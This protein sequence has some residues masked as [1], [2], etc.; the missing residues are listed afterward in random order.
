[1]PKEAFKSIQPLSEKQIK[2][3]KGYLPSHLALKL[4]KSPLEFSI[5]IATAYIFDVL[6]FSRD[7][8]LTMMW[9]RLVS[10]ALSTSESLSKWFLSFLA[11]KNGILQ[12]IFFKSP[13][14]VTKKAASQLIETALKTLKHTELPKYDEQKRAIDNSPHLASIGDV[15][16]WNIVMM[17]MLVRLIKDASTIGRYSSANFFQT[18]KMVC[19]I[20]VEERKFL[21]E[22]DCLTKLMQFIL[23]HGEY[24]Y[25]PPRG[26]NMAFAP[27]QSQTNVGSPNVSPPLEVLYSLLRGIKVEADELEDLLPPPTRY[28]EGPTISLNE[29]QN[30]LLFGDRF[31]V[32]V[33]REGS[34]LKVTGQVLQ[35]LAWQSSQK[36]DLFL[37]ALL[38]AMSVTNNPSSFVKYSTILLYLMEIEDD[39]Q[40]NRIQSCLKMIL[41]YVSQHSKSNEIAGEAM[42]FFRR[43]CT[44]YPAIQA[45]ISKNTNEINKVF[46]PAHLKL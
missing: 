45:W 30:A 28:P 42:Y 19:E 34:D 15:V 37:A 41:D 22:R 40:S 33:I 1:M 13:V 44:K 31:F 2:K 21:M 18:L 8:N 12:A 29:E 16:S 3:L 46:Q 10:N 32:R 5:A 35:Y 17:E 6:P 26:K 25:Q 38:D 20:G 14:S 36:T 24:A 9:T 11:T 27:K 43:R 39:L 23:G 4:G 7:A